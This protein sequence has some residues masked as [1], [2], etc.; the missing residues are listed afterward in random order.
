M[1]IKVNKA[2]L[3]YNYLLWLDPILELTKV[4]RS[5]LASLLTLHYHNKDKIQEPELSELIISDETFGLIRKKLRLG[6]KL[7][8]EGILKLKLK[9]YLLEKGI[10]PKFTNYNTNDKFSILVEFQVT[11]E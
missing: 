10:A 9:G 6:K 11:N 5:I 7:F 2:N 1:L 3:F 8:D 4:E